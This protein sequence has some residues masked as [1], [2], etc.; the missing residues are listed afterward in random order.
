MTE[1]AG[2]PDKLGQEFLYATNVSRG[3]DHARVDAA[4]RSFSL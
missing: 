1:R 4:I 2:H 3:N